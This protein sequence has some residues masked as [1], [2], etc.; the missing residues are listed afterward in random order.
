MIKNKNP[1]QPTLVH[2]TED[3]KKYE[4]VVIVPNC[5]TPSKVAVTGTM[6]KDVDAFFANQPMGSFYIGEIEF[7]ITQA[8]LLE[9]CQNLALSVLGDGFEDCEVPVPPVQE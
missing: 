8:G 1:N 5:Y 9:A 6:F 3:Y 7:D 2:G 4:Y